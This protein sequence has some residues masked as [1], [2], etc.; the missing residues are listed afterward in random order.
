MSV[1]ELLQL[2]RDYWKIEN[3]LHYIKDFVFNEDR[4]TIRNK[5]G[6]HNMNSL[7][8]FAI[9]FFRL[10]EVINIKRCVENIRYA[11][12]SDF[13]KSIFY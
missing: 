10:H 8:N 9:S 3:Q 13:I 4:S 1:E 6:A 7:R 12:S 11:S 2:N 5:N